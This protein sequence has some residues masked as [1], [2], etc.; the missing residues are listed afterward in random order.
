MEIKKSITI[1]QY[2]PSDS[3]LHLLDPRTKLI[4]VMGFIVMIF[5]VQQLYG[6]L[7][8]LGL[9]IILI[10]ISSIPF[11]NTFYCSYPAF[12][13]QGCSFVDSGSIDRH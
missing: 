7:L 5:F 4:S 6:Y 9:M 8:L 1:G 13:D 11:S 3:F 12:Y 2:I 10:L